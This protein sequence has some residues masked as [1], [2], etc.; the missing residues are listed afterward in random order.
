[1]AAAD[2]G[3]Q[4]YFVGDGTAPVVDYAGTLAQL[5]DLLT[6][7]VRAESDFPPALT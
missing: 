2:V 3:M 7:L 1:M 4:T 6:R 5:P